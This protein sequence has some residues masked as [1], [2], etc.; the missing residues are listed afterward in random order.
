MLGRVGG[1]LDASQADRNRTR[2]GGGLSH[3]HVGVLVV[4]LIYVPV[5]ERRSQAAALPYALE[6]RDVLGQA[7]TGSGKTAVFGL[8]ALQRLDLSAASRGVAQ[9]QVAPRRGGCCTRCSLIRFVSS[10]VPS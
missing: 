3:S 2:L 1:V 10:P 6:G 7:A 4:Y 9:P 5:R 8:A